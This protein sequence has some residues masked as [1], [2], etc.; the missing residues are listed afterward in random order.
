[1][2][3]AKTCST[4]IVWIYHDHHRPITISISH[5]HLS[6]MPPH[7]MKPII[8]ITLTQ[9][10]TTINRAA[11]TAL[12]TEQ[13]FCVQSKLTGQTTAIGWS[14]GLCDCYLIDG[15]CSF[16]LLATA[17]PCVA[18]GMNYSLLVNDNPCVLHDCW[19]PCCLFA[20]LEAVSLGK[21]IDEARRGNCCNWTDTMHIFM[22]AQHQYAAGNSIGAYGNS[23]RCTECCEIYW[24]SAC[25]APCVQTRVRNEVI[26]RRVTNQPPRFKPLSNT[27]CAFACC[28]RDCGCAGCV[29]PSR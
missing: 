25:C 7:P 8:T 19:R 22:I 9:Q 16:C 13:M 3:A 24:Q 1:V 6:M 14:T 5:Q 26:R 4:E 20:V 21:E 23:L 12:K 10:P 18:Y 2:S 28:A 17:C 11:A 15:G 27:L 29:E